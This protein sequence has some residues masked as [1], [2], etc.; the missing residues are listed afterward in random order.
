LCPRRHPALQPTLR[1]GEQKY[2]PVLT[3]RAHLNRLTNLLRMRTI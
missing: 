1:D 2:Q 3:T